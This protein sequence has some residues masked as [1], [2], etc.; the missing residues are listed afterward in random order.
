MSAWSPSVLRGERPPEGDLELLSWVFALSRLPEA[1]DQ[2]AI[3]LKALGD[4]SCPAVA[5]G[6]HCAALRCSVCVINT[7]KARLV[8]A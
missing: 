3:L 6:I 8:L 4:I 5:A 1:P 2:F 7:A